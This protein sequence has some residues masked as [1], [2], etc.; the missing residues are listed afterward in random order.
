MG[1][2]MQEIDIMMI[3]LLLTAMNCLNVFGLVVS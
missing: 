3:V 2:G 1:L